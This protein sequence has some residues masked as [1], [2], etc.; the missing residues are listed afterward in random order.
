MSEEFTRRELLKSS[1][2]IL[3]TGLLAPQLVL[4]DVSKPTPSSKAERL[5]RLSLNEN[6]YGP[7]PNVARAVQLELGRLSR[8]ADEPLARRLAE[9]I[10]EHEQIPVEQVVLGEILDLLGSF[11]QQLKRSGWRVPL[12]DSRV[13]CSYRRGSA[14]GRHRRSGP[15]KCAIPE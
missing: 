15:F 4:A 14:R 1:G 3:G 8:Y 12:L 2:I 9:Q 10:A 7:S 13:S 11:S 6:P 5:V